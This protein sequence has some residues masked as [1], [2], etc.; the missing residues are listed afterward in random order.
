MRREREDIY[1]EA[2]EKIAAFDHAGGP[3]CTPTA[4]IYEC[5]CFDKSQREIAIEALEEAEKVSQ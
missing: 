3:H 5:C 2:L 1:R 4:P